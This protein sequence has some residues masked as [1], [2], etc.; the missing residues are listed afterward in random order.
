MRHSPIIIANTIKTRITESKLQPEKPPKGSTLIG[1]SLFDFSISFRVRLVLTILLSGLMLTM[2]LFGIGGQTLSWAAPA[3]NPHLQTVPPRPPDD[4]P[5]PPDSDP[6]AE[7]PASPSDRGDGDNTPAQP[8]EQ[9]DNE[10]QNESQP[11]QPPAP[12]DNGG[13]DTVQPT[14]NPKQESGPDQN[15]VPPAPPSQEEV[16]G[17]SATSP[18][19]DLSLSQTVDNPTPNLAEVITFTIVISNNGPSKATN[20]VVSDLL[21]LG[22]ILSSTMPS[23]GRYNSNTGLWAV[24]TITHSE[25]ITLS[26]MV[27]VTSAG[28]VTNTAEIAAAHPSDPDST[29]GN[30]L[31]HEDDWD[32][33]PI[34]TLLETSPTTQFGSDSVTFAS[35]SASAS[36]SLFG[37]VG[38]L[39][40]LYALC[41]GAI[42]ILSGIYLVNRA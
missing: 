25:S 1:R 19:A 12:Q 27:T 3:Q 26:L 30:G 11:T 28:T 39:S 24:G 33:V 8:P 34:V 37:W 6:P 40:W 14:P 20:V 22:L 10:S 21:P 36:G 17:A 7:A 16:D 15:Q 4:D 31:E 2:G 42:L 5:P 38:S 41:L 32:S 35:A 9:Q 23:Q 29:P 18:Q 13:Q